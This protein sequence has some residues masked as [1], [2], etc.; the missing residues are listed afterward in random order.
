MK[1]YSASDIVKLMEKQSF[2]DWYEEIFIPYIEGE[3][4]FEDVD[5]VAE[6]EHLLVG[7]GIEVEA[8]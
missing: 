1:L 7:K 2:T 4:G 8:A 3:E 6:L 5:P